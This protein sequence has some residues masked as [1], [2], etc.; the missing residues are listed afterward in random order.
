MKKYKWSYEQFD[1]ADLT[2][3][4]K[5]LLENIELDF[6]PLQKNLLQLNEAIE[7]SPDTI[8]KIFKSSEELSRNKKLRTNFGKSIN[9]PRDVM[10]KVNNAVGALGKRLQD[11]TPIKMFDQKF[12]QAKS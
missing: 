9:L 7:L 11:S 8:E 5:Q 6:L 2:P 1:W 12:D 3:Q 10:I 4:N